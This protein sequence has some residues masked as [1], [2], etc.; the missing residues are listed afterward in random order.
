MQSDLCNHSA[1]MRRSLAPALALA[2]AT[3]GCA[4]LTELDQSAHEASA[5]VAPPHPVYGT[6]IF[7][8]VPE[9]QEVAAAREAWTQIEAAF[10]QQGIAIDP[11][12][13]RLG[14]IR[15]V[16]QRL[17]EVAHR[18]QLP[19]EVHLL[20]AE[21]VN[22]FT[23]GGGL[24]VVLD[25]LFGGLVEPGDEDELSCVLAHEVAHVTL[26]HVP[27]R[28]TWSR[29]AKLAVK[30][31]TGEFYQ[32]AYTTEQEAEADRIAALYLAL[33]GFDPT[34]ASRIWERAHQRSGSSA[35]ASGF[36]YDHPLDAERITATR[37]VAAQVAAYYTPGEKNPDWKALLASSVLYQR[38]E[39][40]PYAPGAV[41]KRDSMALEQPSEER[42]DCSIV[43]PGELA[44]TK[45]VDLV[46]GQ[47]E[48]SV[49]THR[50]RVPRD[51]RTTV[52]PRVVVD[53][54]DLDHDASMRG[55][56]HQEI[57]ALTEERVT[58]AP[59]NRDGVVV[60]P[61]FG[62]QGREPRDLGAER[63]VVGL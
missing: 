44:R 22:A 27:T 3:A 14:Q 50:V 54:I 7:N 51:I 62:E 28:S 12:G 43:A 21:D 35:A 58:T 2:A 15:A 57:H 18:Q 46:A 9:E 36:L 19:W 41:V 24:V 40:T 32:A 60:K 48:V 29:F 55:K 34:A 42:L 33:A 56:E 39:E 59:A 11:A 13:E 10:R 4:T 63:T 37:E 23:A 17:V 8:L 31:A 47:L 61:D 5:A 52:S 6:P 30:D 49:S 16:F 25:G 1:A 45:P 38:S 20:G 53:A 26:L